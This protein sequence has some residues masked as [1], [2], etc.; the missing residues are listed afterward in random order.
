MPFH[1]D[2]A[3]FTARVV[4][5][6]H[7]W[8]AFHAVWQDQDDRRFLQRSRQEQSSGMC[9]SAIESV[10]NQSRDPVVF[11]SSSNMDGHRFLLA[12]PTAEDCV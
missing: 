5:G 12:M 6:D 1:V 7:M 11:V 3:E 4:R 2:G 10:D 8:E 9:T